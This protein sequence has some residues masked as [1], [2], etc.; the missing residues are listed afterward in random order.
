MG[1][2]ALVRDKI[3]RILVDEMELDVRLI[4]E[5][6]QVPYASTAVNIRVVEQGDG[7][8]SRVLIKMWAPVLRNVN[9]SAEVFRW[10]AVEGA[11]YTF[12][13]ACWNPDPQRPGVGMISF[14]HTLLGDYLDSEEMTTAIVA[15][16]L[17][18]DDLDDGLQP[19]FGGQR[20]IDG[21]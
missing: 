18:A 13:H 21:D 9:E 16:A 10:I 4:S 3:Q 12:G 8:A 15:L 20:F 7:D 19:R 1:S 5:G 11:V 14:D 2:A 6:F 17:T